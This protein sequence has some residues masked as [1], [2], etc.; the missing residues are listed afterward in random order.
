M[1]IRSLTGGLVEENVL[2]ENIQHPKQIC[3]KYFLY[4][5]CKRLAWALEHWQ[6]IF[7]VNY[8]IFCFICCQTAMLR[9]HTNTQVS[10]LSSCYPWHASGSCWRPNSV[11]EAQL[12]MWAPSQQK[13][14]YLATPNCKSHRGRA[15]RIWSDLNPIKPSQAVMVAPDVCALLRFVHAR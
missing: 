5:S 8:F 7:K 15:H 10:E 14:E 6:T 2:W 12:N 1:G 11:V 9:T 3:S 4:V 13:N